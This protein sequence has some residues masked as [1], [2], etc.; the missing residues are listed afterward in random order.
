MQSRNLFTGWYHLEHWSPVPS[1]HRQQPDNDA[2]S[3][4]VAELFMMKR[5]AAGHMPTSCASLAMPNNGLKFV[6]YAKPDMFKKYTLPADAQ[7]VIGL[8]VSPQGNQVLIVNESW[9]G[10][11]MV[12]SYKSFLHMIAD[13]FVLWGFFNFGYALRQMDWAA[14][15]GE[16]PT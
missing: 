2:K 15:G 4:L 3:T 16:R 14:P 6:V 10:H 7:L 13:V 8:R 12:K 1:K 11:S 5:I 9:Q